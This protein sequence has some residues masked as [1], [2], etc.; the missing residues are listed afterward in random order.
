M[1]PTIGGPTLAGAGLSYGLL[2][3][4]DTDIHSEASI[5][6][7]GLTWS[8]ARAELSALLACRGLRIYCFGPLAL[9]ASCCRARRPEEVI[10]EEPS[11]HSVAPGRV[12][13]RDYESPGQG[14]EEA[15]VEA[16]L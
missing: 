5:L 7:G 3:L 14:A 6:R 12:G 13:A 10:E 15:E 9:R 11:R 4:A 1:S 2:M 16:L 8:A